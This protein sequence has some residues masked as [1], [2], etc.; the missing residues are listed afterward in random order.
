MSRFNIVQFTPTAQ[1][2][3]L[4][5]IDAGIDQ[6]VMDF[7]Q[8][9]SIWRDKNP[10]TKEG[11]DTGLEKTPDR[12]SRKRVSDIISG[13]KKLT[14]VHQGDMQHSRAKSGERIPLER[15]ISQARQ[16]QTDSL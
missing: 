1:E 6:R 9:N 11:A 4:W 13:C 12:R 15:V 5:A 16:R 10:D 14:D 2:W 8:E 7:I 3:L